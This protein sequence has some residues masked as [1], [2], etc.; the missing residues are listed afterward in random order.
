MTKALQYLSLFLIFSLTSV[1]FYTISVNSQSVLYTDYGRFYQSAR[2]AMTKHDIY[3]PIYVSNSAKPKIAPKKIS[4]NLNPPF[5]QVISYPFGFMSYA[6]SL[7]LWSLLSLIFGT[8][9]LAY[10]WKILEIKPTS[11]LFI[12]S[13]LALLAYTPTYTTLQCGQVSFILLLP[14]TAGWFLARIGKTNL[15]A[16]LIGIAASCKPFLLLFGLFYLFRK[17]WSGLIYFTFTLIACVALTIPIFGIPSYI[18]YIKVLSH[19]LWYADNW[20]ASLYG[21]LS[22][23]FGNHYE[24]HTV[25]TYAPNLT[26]YLYYTISAGIITFMAMLMTSKK[27]IPVRDKKEKLNFDFTLTLIFS[28]LLSPL[29]WTYYFVFLLVPFMLL[30]KKLYQEN[31]PYTDALYILLALFL[32]DISTSLIS[33]SELAAHVYRNFFFGSCYFISL[34]ILI[35]MTIKLYRPTKENAPPIKRPHLSTD[36]LSLLIIIV[37]LPAVLASLWNVNQNAIGKDR[38]IPIYN[39]VSFSG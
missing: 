4:D 35:F 13:L 37:L 12:T 29:G 31:L 25:L 11:F 17:E 39:E 33:T 14:L 16:V 1:F 23:L 15:S 3:L 36:D 28:L 32:S 6:N 34:I 19:I 5:F 30:F 18:S 38:L 20:N 2:L 10:A 7:Y 24:K 9:S 26:K 21:T 8:I 22:R 27:F